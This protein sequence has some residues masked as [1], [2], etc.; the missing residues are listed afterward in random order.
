[1]RCVGSVHFKN[2]VYISMET[3]L[4]VASYFGDSIS[5]VKLL[6]YLEASTGDCYTWAR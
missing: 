3:N 2:T 1:M 6:R 5:P 4:T